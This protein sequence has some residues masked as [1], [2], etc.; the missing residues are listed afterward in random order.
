[1][2]DQ[3]TKVKDLIL[4]L[5]DQNK[6]LAAQLD[7]LA[8]TV[9]HLDRQNGRLQEDLITSNYAANDMH[10]ERNA[11]VAALALATEQIAEL[12]RQ[13]RYSTSVNQSAEWKQEAKETK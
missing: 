12:R 1:M 5:T 4:A 10:R 9:S 3:K 11:L 2:K 13:V 8:R 7:E 6:Q